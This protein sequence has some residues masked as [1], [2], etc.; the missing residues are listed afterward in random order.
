MNAVSLRS[1]RAASSA[2]LCFLIAAGCRGAAQ[3][4]TEPAPEARPAQVKAAPAPG[5]IPGPPDSAAAPRSKDPKVREVED[6]L[7]QTDGGRVLLKAIRVH[8]GWER[9]REVTNIAALVRPRK[10]GQERRL[11]YTPARSEGSPEELKLLTAPFSLAD[12]AFRYDYQGV[13][14]D[15]GT[16]DTFDKVQVARPAAGGEWLVAY[17]SRRTGLLSRALFP[18]QVEAGTPGQ[19]PFERIDLSRQRETGGV[20]LSTLWTR[21]ALRNRLAR[22]DIAHPQAVE[23]LELQVTAR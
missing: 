5:L 2:A 14:I 1:G 19:A 17:V 16:G 9:W 13:E 11:V 15:A 22:A 21:F 4:Q 8:G 18:R 23:E 3:K 7:F 20:L 10:E 6:R 12:P